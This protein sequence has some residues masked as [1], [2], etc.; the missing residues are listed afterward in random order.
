MPLLDPQYEHLSVRELHPTFGAEVHGV[1][2]SNEIP[3][4]QFREILAVMTKYG[5]AVFRKTSLSDQQHVDFSRRL[6]DLDD[7]RPYLVGG[8]KPR[9]GLV[10]I[11]DASNISE[12]GEVL[13]PDAPRSHYG[14]GNA[15]WH[16]DS[17]FNPRR[18]S[19]SL[20]RAFE[21]PPTGQGLG[22][23]TDFAD[24]RTAFEEL[25]K[26]LKAE[27]MEK[28]YVGAHS[29]FHSR[30]LGSPEFFKDVDPTEHKMHLHKIVQK[31]E[32]SQR[33]NLYV[34]THAHHIDGLPVQEGQE[35]LDRLI[36]HCTQ[37]KYTVSVSWHDPGDMIVWDNTCVMHRATGGAFEGRYRRDLRR[38]TVHDASSTAWGLNEPVDSREGFDSAGQAVK[39]QKL[40]LS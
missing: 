23:D 7:I 26:E 27:L 19:Y 25:P 40:G 13:H 35:I 20:L 8:R 28:D 15:L 21:I 29:L 38:T 2:F 3:D 34:A 9:C 6:G 4:E 16:V 5:F 36:K 39:V 30:K 32:P 17:S 37:P 11:F 18:A 33:M 22:G 10:E 12:E 14:K 1:D 24:T 31:H